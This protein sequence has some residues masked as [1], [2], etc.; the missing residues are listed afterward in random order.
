MKEENQVLNLEHLSLK[1]GELFDVS[2]FFQYD[3]FTV[4]TN[5]S[6]AA[7]EV[8]I[9]VIQVISVMWNDLNVT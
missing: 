9:P 4:H 5:A 3:S 7:D 8:E 1:N 2:V 6:P